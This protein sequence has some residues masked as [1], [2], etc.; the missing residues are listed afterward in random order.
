MP[1]PLAQLAQRDSVQRD[2][3]PQRQLERDQHGH[4]RSQRACHRI[5][6]QVGRTKIELEIQGR[7]V[8]RVQT[9]PIGDL[10]RVLRQV[11]ER[12]IARDQENCQQAQAER[13][14]GPD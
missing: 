4:D 9:N 13:N 14:F 2:R 5:A 10:Q 12:Q 3:R 7:A 1:Q 6:E 8:V 11:D